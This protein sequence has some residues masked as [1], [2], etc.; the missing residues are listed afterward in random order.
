MNS[1][2]VWHMQREKD[3]P[4]LK[5]VFKSPILQ[6]QGACC[7]TK[8][9]LQLC[10]ELAFLNRYFFTELHSKCVYFLESVEIGKRY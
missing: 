7:D 3:Q 1:S 10:G 6:I 4:C 9:L 8:L 2:G 5:A